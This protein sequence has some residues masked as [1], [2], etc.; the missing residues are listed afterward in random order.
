MND[1]ESMTPV[2][3]TSF[4]PAS[5]FPSKNDVNYSYSQETVETE[6]S[7][8]VTETWTSLNGLVNFSRTVTSPKEVEVSEEE[9]RAQIKK[10]VKE[11][12]YETAASLKRKLYSK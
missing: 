4:K 6:N 12:D 2:W 7:T 11:E 8:T 10:A 1:F 5:K 9:I 3:S